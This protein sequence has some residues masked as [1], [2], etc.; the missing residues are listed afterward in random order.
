MKSFKLHFPNKL[1]YTYQISL[2]LIP[3]LPLFS[4][5]PSKKDMA[6]SKKV[7]LITICSF[8]EKLLDLVKFVMCTLVSRVYI[9]FYILSK[10]YTVPENQCTHNKLNQIQVIYRF[11]KFEYVICFWDFYRVRNSLKVESNSQRLW[12]IIY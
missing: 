1:T 12:H 7:N 6:N 4:G 2:N 3:P 5:P 9:T 11:K 8:S 10:G